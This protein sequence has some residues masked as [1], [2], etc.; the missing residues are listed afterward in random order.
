M[1]DQA[2]QYLSIFSNGKAHPYM[3]CLW[4]IH[5]SSFGLVYKDFRHLNSASH[6]T[7]IGLMMNDISDVDNAEIGIWASRTQN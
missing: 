2:A 5:L 1:P 7:F 3:V 4:Y 6:C